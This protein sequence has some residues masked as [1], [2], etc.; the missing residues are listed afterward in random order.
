MKFLFFIAV[1]RIINMQIQNGIYL[2][3]NLNNNNYL[4]IENNNLILSNKQTNFR[5][6]LIKY[7]I[8]IIETKHKRKKI[9]YK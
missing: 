9:R 3:K 4:T 6:I 1:L 8:Y 7:N 5:I 2:I